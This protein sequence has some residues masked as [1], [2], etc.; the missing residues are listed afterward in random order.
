MTL[1]DEVDLEVGLLIWCEILLQHMLVT[2]CIDIT[3]QNTHDQFKIIMDAS[4]HVHV[5]ACRLSY[6]CQSMQ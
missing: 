5:T 4:L 6:L 3:F 2:L 1:S